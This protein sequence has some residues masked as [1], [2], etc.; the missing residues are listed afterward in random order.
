MDFQTIQRRLGRLSVTAGPAGGTEVERLALQLLQA[1]PDEV[2]RR[3]V[4]R[5]LKRA[6]L[7]HT[8]IAA[9]DVL[10]RLKSD[11]SADT[12]VAS[13]HFGIAMTLVEDLLRQRPA[14]DG[15]RRWYTAV[16]AF[17][18]A[19]HDIASA[20]LFL[21]RALERFPDDS[22]L[23][24]IAGA[25][26]E[27]LASP[28][29]Q[30][31]ILPDD[32]RLAGQAFGNARASWQG[33]EKFFAQALNKNQGLVE[34][35]LHRGRVLGQLG[36]WGEA[37]AELDLTLRSFPPKP[38]QYLA[39]LFIGENES[40]LSHDARAE[41]AYRQAG[42]LYPSA[43]SAQIGASYLARQQDNHRAAAR[44]LTLALSTA[45]GAEREDPWDSYY[46]TAFAG[47]SGPL[48]DDLR[49]ILTADG[50]R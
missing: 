39:W 23:L 41:A 20:P 6:I 7:L 37:L 19:Q 29:V 36:R 27:F 38:V 11:D 33:A 13:V 40:A 26:H 48:L 18:H 12:P 28:V 31:N 30:D 2:R 42:A 44:M 35:R 32:P 9:A 10:T 8:D 47:E 14:D 16:A 15:S 22:D 3:D 21:R 17:L 24:S 5:E 46:D 50:S 25:V 1:T 4:T 45:L 43:P 49:R 34:V